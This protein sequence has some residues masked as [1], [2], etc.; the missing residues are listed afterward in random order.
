MGVEGELGGSSPRAVHRR[1]V[2]RA[3]SWGGAWRPLPERMGTGVR[4][5]FPGGDETPGRFA[6]AREAQCR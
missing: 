2:A 4:L 3:G 6:G 5:A 1:T